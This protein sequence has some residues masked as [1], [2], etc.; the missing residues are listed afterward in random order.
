[1]DE[2][3]LGSLADRSVDRRLDLVCRARL[4]GNYLDA[5]FSRRLRDLLRDQNAMHGVGRI[6]QHPDA[7][8]L[9]GDL[10]Q[11]VQRLRHEATRN[12][13]GHSRQ[14]AAGPGEIRNEPRLDRVANGNHHYRGRRRSI[15]NG[16]IRLR[17][18]RND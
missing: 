13:G 8:R 6:D 3:G 15:L 11:K 17:P 4:D 12:H 7:S 10:M 18:R 9:R 14:V 16:A 1:L 5:Q 2:E